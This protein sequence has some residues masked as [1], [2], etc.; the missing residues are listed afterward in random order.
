MVQSNFEPEFAEQDGQ[1]VRRFV[2]FR[3]SLVEFLAVRKDQVHIPPEVLLRLLAVPTSLVQ[4]VVL[5]HAS[6]DCGYVHGRLDHTRVVIVRF[7][8][9]RLCR[10]RLQEVCRLKVVVDLTQD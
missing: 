2:Y 7:L 9:D 3:A 4:I 8:S 5:L 6:H 1:S 10:D